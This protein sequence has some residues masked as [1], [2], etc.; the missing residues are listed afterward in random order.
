M[1]LPHT[2]EV[3]DLSIIEAFMLSHSFA[4]LITN[5]NGIPFASQVPLL[6]DQVGK[7]GR[8]LGH[9]AKANNQWRKFDGKTD[10]LIVF[11][12]PHAYIS[13]NWYANENLVP[14]WNYVSV[15]AYGKPNII[16]N[17]TDTIEVMRKLINFYESNATGNWSIDNLT[18]DFIEKKIKGIVTFEIPIDRVEGKFKLSQNREL[19][20]RRG[21]IQGLLD[22]G[23]SE[24]GKVAQLMINSL[25][26]QF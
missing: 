25:P 2:F 18:S 26:D 15:H 10:A 11:S 5:I 21:A 23:D 13:P 7:H 17:P 6:L 16:S 3:K 24:A 20:D 8:L 19:K 1:F 4:Q 14:T 9:I 22:T 12:G